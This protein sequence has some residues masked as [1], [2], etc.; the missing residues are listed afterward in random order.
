M[1]RAQI[2]LEDWQ[3]EELRG[4]SQREGKSLSGLVRDL[5]SRHLTARKRGAGVED[6]AGIARTGRRK[7][8]HHDE[9]VYRHGRGVKG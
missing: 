6:I 9:I 7:R 3:L 2:L 1:R 8:K 5:V 4:E